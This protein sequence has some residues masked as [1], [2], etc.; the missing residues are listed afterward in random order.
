MPLKTI[1]AGLVAA[2]ICY[3]G[4]ELLCPGMCFSRQNCAVFNK[5]LIETGRTVNREWESAT[6]ELLKSN[7]SDPIFSAR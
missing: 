4:F 2:S 3:G 6:K 7:K 1:V 5:K